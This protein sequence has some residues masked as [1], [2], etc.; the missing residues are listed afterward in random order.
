MKVAALYDIHG[1]LPALEAVLEEIEQAHFDL[2]VIGGDIGPGPMPKQTLQRLLDL[3]DHARF[4][5]VLS[6]L[7]K[8]SREG[9]P[10][11]GIL[12]LTTDL[13]Q[14]QVAIRISDTGVGIPSELLPK[15]FE[16]FVT[17]GK[18]NSTGLG[19]AIAKS[20]VEA[21]GGKISLS[22]VQGSGTTVDVRLPKPAE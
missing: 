17:H 18:T 8:N 13:V 9:M 14:D 20:V 6:N 22:S 19:L 11:G 4:I 5:R 12:T 3:G 2:I 10:G 21:H 1:N 7:I 15:L 16:P